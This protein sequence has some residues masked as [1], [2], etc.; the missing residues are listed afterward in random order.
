M[1]YIAKNDN[2]RQEIVHIIGDDFI[3]LKI[4]AV[5]ETILYVTLSGL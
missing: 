3:V 5:N 1:L 2:Y 4:M